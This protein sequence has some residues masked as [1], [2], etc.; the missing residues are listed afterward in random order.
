MDIEE[1]AKKIQDL[2]G[3]IEEINKKWQEKFGTVNC[4]E[5]Q[6]T[7]Y[8]IST[9]LYRNEPS[10]GYLNEQLSAIQT[11]GTA[12]AGEVGLKTW[13]GVKRRLG[14]GKLD[15]GLVEKAKEL[16]DEEEKI[17]KQVRDW[18]KERDELADKK[19][20]LMK[21]KRELLD[22]PVE[23][24]QKIKDAFSKLTPFQLANIG[25][26]C[27]CNTA[28]S[29]GSFY[30]GPPTKC[31]NISHLV[32]EF[33]RRYIQNLIPHSAVAPSEIDKK[34][35]DFMER[36][37]YYEIMDKEDFDFKKDVLDYK[38]L[39]YQEKKVLDP[40]KD[41]CPPGDYD[42]LANDAICAYSKRK[43][44]NYGENETSVWNRCTYMQYGG[45]PGFWLCAYKIKKQ[46]ENR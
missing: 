25:T 44:C 12:L 34:I 39:S 1:K 13:N 18:R 38:K 33:T 31:T 36:K 7:E 16:Y 35:K 32:G 42:K 46:F 10:W 11:K 37:H 45:K 2:D 8:D 27:N 9:G 21:K 17:Y 4:K 3:L 19:Y 22:V 29:F 14:S 20:E 26:Q 43:S 6:I 15:S 40:E 5:E 30:S 41:G 28:S 23:L 24:S